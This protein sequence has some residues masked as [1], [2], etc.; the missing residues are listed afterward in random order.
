MRPA[1]G[2][3]QCHLKTFQ[4]LKCL[5]VKNDHHMMPAQVI[6]IHTMRDNT[7]PWQCNSS[8]Y[9]RWHVCMHA[10]IHMYSHSEVLRRFDQQTFLYKY[11]TCI[12]H[13]SW[14]SDDEMVKHV[15]LMTMRN[16]IDYVDWVHN[17]GATRLRHLV[18]HSNS[19]VVFMKA[20]KG[21]SWWKPWI[22]LKSCQ[23]QSW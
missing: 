1:S 8:N 9:I 10:N 19:C 7:I 4:D 13:H 17:L 20:N 15:N 3:I 23:I 12:Y 21:R 16:N 11:S 18:V 6:K 2:S 22:V 5:G 14:L